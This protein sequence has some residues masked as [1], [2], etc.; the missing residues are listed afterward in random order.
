MKIYSFT[1][2]FLITPI[3][4]ISQIIWDFET[5]I[6]VASSSFGNSSAQLVIDQAGN[7]QIIMGK[8]NVGL[9]FVGSE[10]GVFNNP[11]L[12][13]TT[14]NVFINN[15][16]GPIV[17]RFNNSIGISCKEISNGSASAKFIQ[18][19]NNGNSWN[20]PVDIFTN[21]FEDFSIPMFSYDGNGN[22]FVISKIGVFP[23]VF[24]GFSV[25]NDGGLTFLPY[26]NMISNLGNGITCECCPSNPVFFNNRFYNI[27]R[28]N[29]SNLRDFW[30]ISS[31]DGI[32]WDNQI[33]VDP[34]DWII[35]G[36]PSSGA[37]TSLLSDNELATVF[38]SGSYGSPKIY[39]NVLNP[40]QNNNGT[41]L[42]LSQNQFLN[43]IQNHPIISCGSTHTAIVWEQFESNYHIMLSI[44]E[45]ENVINGLVDVAEKISINVN[46][47][48]RFPKVKIFNNKLHLIWQNM[49]EGTVK[50]ISGTIS[51]DNNLIGSKKL[52]KIVNILGQETGLLPNIVLFYLY[53]DGSVEK[54]IFLE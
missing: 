19:S 8:P 31:D 13:P 10:L 22:P 33:D 32:N 51:N 3:A 5:P 36:C 12:I 39:L 14:E 29:E 47:A 15:T 49:D 53:D 28:R 25:S 48:N 9:Y 1:I 18:S 24:E 44:S 46:G 41:T 50:Y 38:M 27:Y 52:H 23:N 7:P 17:D 2:F 34:T 37:N 35:N 45:N 11:Q 40:S 42:Q 30:I 21:N 20:S 16:N 26:E 6:N 4:L 43:V 54:K